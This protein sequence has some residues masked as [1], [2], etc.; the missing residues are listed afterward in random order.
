MGIDQPSKHLSA[1]AS[2]RF[3]DLQLSHLG[4]LVLETFES[5]MLL[6]STVDR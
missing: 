2:G 6:I 1:A 5:I 3:R 4:K